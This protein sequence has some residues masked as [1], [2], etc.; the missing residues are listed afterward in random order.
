MR[1]G[2][3]AIFIGGD[4]FIAHTIEYQNELWLVPEWLIVQVH[5]EQFAMPERI[6]PLVLLPFEEQKRPNWDRI[7]PRGL[8]KELLTGAPSPEELDRLGILLKPDIRYPV[9]VETRNM[10]PDPTSH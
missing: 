10:H 6:I 8:T 1:V 5:G 2:D 3:T 7:V 4:I 9:G